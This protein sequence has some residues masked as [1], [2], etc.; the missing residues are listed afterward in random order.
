MREKCPKTGKVI[1]KPDECAECEFL[2]VT[3]PAGWV[4]TYH[5][6]Q[7]S[8]ED[9]K[10]SEDEKCVV[11]GDPADTECAR[12]GVPLCSACANQCPEC[13]EDYCD[14]CFDLDVNLCIN[15]IQRKVDEDMEQEMIG[16][17]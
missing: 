5:S 14:E 11:C 13:L 10:M 3:I 16:D 2:L 7:R 15:C 17:A 12:C 6:E 4:C 9:G 8:K 1:D